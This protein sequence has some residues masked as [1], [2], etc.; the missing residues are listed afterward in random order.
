MTIERGRRRRCEGAAAAEVLR[1]LV[2]ERDGLAGAAQ[3]H[4]G[5]DAALVAGQA[6]TQ[7]DVDD[8]EEGEIGLIAIHDSGA[9]VDVGFGGIGLDQA[10][11]EAV[12]GRAGDLVDCGARDGEIVALGLR[13]TLGQRYAQLGRDRLAGREIGDK[14][15]D[16]REKFA[17]RQFGESDGSDGAWRNPFGEHDGDASG[18]DGS[19]ARAGASLDQDRPI[20]RG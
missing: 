16:T 19:L 3:D 9:R 4:F 2:K 20:M 11:A 8:L 13:Q 5:E 15:A 10:L 12:D 17:R 18:H 1:D 6:L 14:I 7:P